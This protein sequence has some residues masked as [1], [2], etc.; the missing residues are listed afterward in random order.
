MSVEVTLSWAECE[1]AA[2]A[3][4]KR[5]LLALHDDRPDFHGFKEDPWGTH[6]E[7]A[8]SEMAVARLLGH[9]W[10]PWARR[11]AVVSADVGDRFQVRR[12]ARPGWD[13]L[14]HESDR[15]DQVFFLVSGRMPTYAIHGSILG[16]D[17]KQ[18][19]FWGD[20]YGTGRPAFWVPPARLNPFEL[21]VAA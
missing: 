5:Q 2:Y 9:W 4:M 19:E 20:P 12:R 8:G 21:G 3:G 16:G 13:L 1:A 11:P 18:A 10:T 15:D 6:I 17:G 7:S 14:L